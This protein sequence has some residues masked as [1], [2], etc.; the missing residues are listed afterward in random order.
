MAN[1]T[2]LSGIPTLYHVDGDQFTEVPVFTFGTYYTAA[3]AEI[4]IPPDFAALSGNASAKTQAEADHPEN[5]LAWYCEETE[6]PEPE[7]GMMPTKTC[8]QHLR[9]SLL[10]P[11]CVNPDDIS[12]YAFSDSSTNRCPEGMKRMPQ[13]R[14]SSRYDTRAVAPDGWDG[15]APFQLSCSDTPGDGYCFHGDFI[16]GWYKDAAEDMLAGG[17]S[18][19]DDGRFISGSR[20]SSPVRDDCTPADHDPDNGTSDYWVSLEMMEE[21]AIAVP[22]DVA[23]ST[24]SAEGPTLSSGTVSSARPRR[25]G[26]WRKVGG[27]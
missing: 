23:T 20:G 14:I 18:G 7:P 27:E 12:E 8:Q 5:G 11:N 13:L 26:P 1:R 3:Y 15:D 4:P 22:D 19:R 25:R 21:G 17:G 16:N 24:A 2:N 9:F 6:Q 10:F